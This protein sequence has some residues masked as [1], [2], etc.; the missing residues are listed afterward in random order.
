MNP[1]KLSVLDLCPLVVGETASKAFEHT[2]DLARFV[3]TIGYRRYWTAEHHSMAGIASTS[4]EIIIGHIAQVTSRIRVGSGG[5]ML[6]NHAPLRIAEAFR[7]LEAF[8]PGRI[9]LGVGRAPGT[10]TATT[11]ALRGSPDSLQAENFP[12][13]LEELKAY[14][15]SDFVPD[16][17]YQDVVAMPTVS[18]TPE[19]WMLGSSDFGARL[20]AERGM[21]FAFAQHFSSLRAAAVLKLYNEEF[22]PSAALAKP[23]SIV[24]LHVVCAETDEEAE[25]LAHPSDIALYHYRTTGRSRPMPTLQ[26]AQASPLTPVER[27]RL[28]KMS[29]PKIV[30]SPQTVRR[31]L[32]LFLKD[33]PADELMVLTMIPDHEARK[34]SYALLAE[35]LA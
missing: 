2:L 32:N 13:E 35:V 21:P 30:G 15:A 14:L 24:A 25:T 3:E 1:V 8:H 29:F 12:R 5:I 26:E 16:S 34:K 11:I 18:T 22:H 31:E 17:L 9:D 4:P 33:A 23:Q 20:A 28:Q 6:P 27:A 19:L 7:T 10:N